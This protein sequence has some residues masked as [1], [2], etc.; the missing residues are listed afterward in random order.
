MVH[1][2]VMCTL[3]K[4]ARSTHCMP[5]GIQATAF[6][7]P[8]LEPQNHAEVALTVCWV[9]QVQSRAWA[10][11]QCSS[12][13]VTQGRMLLALC[14][15]DDMHD[16]HALTSAAKCQRTERDS[17]QG[18]T[19]VPAVLWDGF[20]SHRTEG[21]HPWRSSYAEGEIC[22]TCMSWNAIIRGTSSVRQTDYTVT[23]CSGAAIAVFSEVAKDT[24]CG[25]R[26]MQKIPSGADSDITMQT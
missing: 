3:V 11:Y 22:S 23:W 7:E 17:A 4:E 15:R 2:I 18:L 13:T 12:S 10:A 8:V 25:E 6:F 9:R 14:V 1:L 19:S 5:L 21:M 20:A 16:Q 26:R 24:R